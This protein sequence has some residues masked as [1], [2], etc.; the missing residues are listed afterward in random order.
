MDEASFHNAL[1][2]CGVAANPTRTAII[3]QGYTNMEEFAELT[4]DDIN[5]LVKHIARL[6]Q[7]QTI[8]FSAVKKLKAMHTWT[9]WQ[10]CQ[11]I[12]IVH[13][14]FNAVALDWAIDRMDDERWIRALDAETPKEP[15]QLKTLTKWPSWW[16]IFD[17]YASQVRGCMFL[18]LKYVYRETEVP[19][20]AQIAANYDTTDDALMALVRLDTADYTTDNHRLWDLLCPLVKDGPGWVWIKRFERQKDA[21][22]AIAA[23]KV[24][25]EGLAAQQSRKAKAYQMINTAKF[26]GHSRCFTYDNYVKVLQRAF[27]ELEECNEEQSESQKVDIF[28]RGLAAPSLHS[29]RTNIC[30]DAE[31]MADFN[32]AQLYVKTVLAQL[33]GIESETGAPHEQNVTSVTSTSAEKRGEGGETG[34]YTHKEWRALSQEQRKEIIQ[35]QQKKTNKNNK[36]K[37]KKEQKKRKAAEL[38]S[39]R[40]S[41]DDDDQKEEETKSPSD[42]FGRKAHAKK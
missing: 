38:A 11:G 8:P 40:D 9:I 6:P 35:K 32:A 7:P 34:Y 1:E 42:Q 21:R 26:T 16:E 23:L 4:E 31:K 33:S 36:N 20:V 28:L 37:K 13:V 24:Q 25:A 5:K 27:T 12:T 15:E 29:A 30:G 39:E 17:A 10:Q 19:T 14:D 41:D 18:L 3:G 2:L 22:R